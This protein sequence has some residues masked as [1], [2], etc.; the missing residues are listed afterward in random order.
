[1]DLS[2]MRLLLSD[3]LSLQEGGKGEGRSDLKDKRFVLGDIQVAR[4]V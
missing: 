1:M 2:S 4:S 3:W